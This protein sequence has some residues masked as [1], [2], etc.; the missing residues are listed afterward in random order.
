MRLTSG[1]E[2]AREFHSFLSRDL[3]TPLAVIASTTEFLQGSPDLTDKLRERLKRIERASRQA[4]ELIEALLLLSRAERRGPTRGEVTDVAKVASDVI[5]S[6]RPQ[7]G[8]K[9]I[10]I[11]L[12]SDGSVAVNAPPSVLSVA[13]TNLIGNAL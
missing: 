7:M 4:T 13:L 10:E 9:P 11:E 5:E 8:G 2:R 1:V 3:R 12:I 6:Q